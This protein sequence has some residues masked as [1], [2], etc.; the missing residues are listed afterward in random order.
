MVASAAKS[1][2]GVDV[3][4]LQDDSNSSEVESAAKTYESQATDDGVRGTPALYIGKTGGTLAPVAA[5]QAS[6]SAAIGRALG[7]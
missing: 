3:Q 5:D 6:L 4:A 2:P 7:Q 1:I